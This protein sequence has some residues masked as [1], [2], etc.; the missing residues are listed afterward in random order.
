MNC[1]CYSGKLYNDCCQPYHTKQKNAPNALALMRSR[2]CAFA[3]HNADYLMDTTLPAKR[4]FHD[5]QDL[6]D[7]AIENI[8]TNLEI[9]EAVDNIVE[10]KAYFM[11]VTSKE[12][13]QQER[14]RFQ[15]ISDRWFYVDGI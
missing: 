5:K 4:R 12:Q 8:W 9:V 15:K 10:F 13:V 14:S 1:L 2:Y 6:L 3:T 7:W 11:D